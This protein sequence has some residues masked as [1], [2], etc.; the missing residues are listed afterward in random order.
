MNQ[1]EDVATAGCFLPAVRCA[2]LVCGGGFVFAIFASWPV[3]RSRLA[4]LLPD[5][6][7]KRK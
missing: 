5:T 7:K 3:T 1:K 4:V 6:V 2:G